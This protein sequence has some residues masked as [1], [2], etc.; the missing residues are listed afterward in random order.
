MR[1]G[2]GSPNAQSFVQ[3]AS[4]SATSVTSNFSVTAGNVILLLLQTEST[5]ASVG[6]VS[7]T[8]NLG[9]V[10]TA[11]ANSIGNPAVNAIVYVGV[12]TQSGIV[13]ITGTQ[14]SSYARMTFTEMRGVSTTIDSQSSGYAA[15]SLSVTVSNSASVIVGLVAN[16]HSATTFTAGTGYTIAVQGN[17]NDSSMIEYIV[18]AAT[19]SNTVTF[20]YTGAGDDNS[21]F[22]ALVF[23]TIPTSTSP[24][25]DGD[26]Y[27]DTSTKRFWGPRLN[28]N[29]SAIGVL[30]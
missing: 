1:S 5:V 25:E 20:G 28:G 8:D 6:S 29:Y 22:F 11:V 17:G 9:T 18:G 27:I 19:G 7:V 4:A 15:T 2:I 13:T 30:S 16:D 12:L 14:G 26:F 3:G 10:Y 24:G 23:E 21:P